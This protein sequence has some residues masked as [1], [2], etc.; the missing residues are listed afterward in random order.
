MAIKEILAFVAALAFY[1]ADADETCRAHEHEHVHEHEHEYEHEHEHEHEHDHAHPT[2][3]FVTVASS[4]Q[5]TL[6]LKTVR[7]E[8]RKLSGSLVVTGRYELAPEARRVVATPVAGH[9][10]LKVHAFSKVAKGDVLFTI[11]A[12]NLVSLAEEIA[13]LEKRLAVYR[14]IKTPNAAL[15]NE[16][17]VKK[18]SR[19]ALLSGAEEANG[20]IVV[21]AMSAGVV[22]ALPATDGAYLDVGGEVVRLVDPAALRI[23]ALVSSVE[24]GRLSDG[25]TCRADGVAGELRIGLDAEAGLIPV[26][27]IFPAGAP[28]GRVGSRASF[29]CETDDAATELVCVPKSAIVKIGLQPTVFVRDESN[30]D[31][32][33]AID[34]A[35]GE[36]VGGWT[37]LTG[38][39]DD[40][41]LEIVTDGAYELKLALA[42]NTTKPTGHFHADGTFHEGED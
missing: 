31:R 9:L 21:R 27:A 8:R 39:P 22:E 10:S 28:K 25:L 11:A 33:L 20:L 37:A 34:I 19:A 3:K 41:D 14:E 35:P 24:L 30:A 36:T 17:A 6:G 13:L 38:L 15:E 2:G 29:S 7:P 40:D 1:V 12:P 42:A 4:V 32:F 16:L 5:Q 26:Y 23:K 18:A